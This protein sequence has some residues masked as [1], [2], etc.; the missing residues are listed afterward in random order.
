M[1][2]VPGFIVIVYCSRSLVADAGVATGR[3]GTSR[4]N[5]SNGV[6]EAERTNADVFFPLIRA[7]L[8]KSN[9]QTSARLPT[10]LNPRVRAERRVIGSLSQF[11]ARV[12]CP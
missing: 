1:S 12:P 4:W 9:E 2:A 11:I 6:D 10:P 8:S 7:F 5:G 3:I